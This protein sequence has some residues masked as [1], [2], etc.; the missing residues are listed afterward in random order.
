MEQAFQ[1]VKKTINSC[2]KI[3]QMRAV[4]RMIWLFYGMYS[5]ISYLNELKDIYNK[6]SSQFIWF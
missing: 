4:Q 2:T 6:K 5:D 3:Q 1:K